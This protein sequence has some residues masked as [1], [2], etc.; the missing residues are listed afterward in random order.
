MRSIQPNI[1][2][3]ARV[4][5]TPLDGCSALTSRTIATECVPGWAA[6]L[7]RATEEVEAP[8]V[9]GGFGPALIYVLNGELGVRSK[10]LRDDKLIPGDCLFVPTA[11]D[12]H[13]LGWSRD[14]VALEV[15]PPS[16]AGAGRAC[17][18]RAA[19][20]PYSDHPSWSWLKRRDLGVRVASNG[21]LGAYLTVCAQSAPEPCGHR[22]YSYQFHLMFIAQ[23][24]CQMDYGEMGRYTLIT[25]DAAV[26]PADLPHEIV[27]RSDDCEILEVVSP[28]GAG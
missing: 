18:T 16:D 26:H 2:K 6:R 5:F 8:H 25:G 12:L 20:T 15:Y 22:S 4:Q 17:L 28:D 9:G 14:A 24:F 7:V 13:R 27:M 10:G 19:Q 3:G 1:T 11:S 23:G 21:Q